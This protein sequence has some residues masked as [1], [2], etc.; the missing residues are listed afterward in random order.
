MRPPISRFSIPLKLF[1]LLLPMVSLPIAI[2]GY[3]AHQTS[4]SS[5]T[6]LSRE[7]QLSQASEAAQQIDAIFQG[8][9]S[10]LALLAQVVDDY[11]HPPAT[12][13]DRLA[14]G[15]HLVKIG[16]LMQH[17]LANTPNASQI[18]QVDASGKRLVGATKEGL[19]ADVAIQQVPNLPWIHSSLPTRLDISPVNERQGHPRYY[20]H[21]SRPVFDEWGVFE[22]ALV[23]ELDFTT[24]IDLVREIEIGANGYGFLVDRAGRTIAHPRFNPYQYDLTRYNDPRLREFIVHMLSGETGW[25][26]FNEEGEKAAAFAPVATTGWSLAVSIPI[27]EFTSMAEVHK[28]NV[29]QVVVVMIL[30]SALVAV[31]VSFRV[32]RPMRNLVLATEQVAAGDLSKEITVHSRDELGLLSE[33][34][35]TMIRS[36]RDIQRELVASEKLI[37]LGRFSAG[38]A[39]EIRNPLNAM[40]GAIAYLQRRRADDP[41][42]AEYTA[43]IAEEVDRLNQFAGDFLLYARQ[44]APRKTPTDINELLRSVLTLL[45]SQ[46]QEKTIS[47]DFRPNDDLPLVH[48]DPQ[49]LQQ[50]FLNVLINALDAMSNN[51]VLS[52]TTALKEKEGSARL[53]I[54]IADNGEGIGEEALSVIFDPF[55]S[56]KDTGTGLGLPISR[57]IIENHAGHL[58]IDSTPGLGTVVTIDMP[59]T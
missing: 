20:L 16:I 50:V 7:H 38:V 53:V 44:S 4:V 14:P 30:L 43:I 24:I 31:I 18:L 28:R 9:I 3:W 47:V 29:I 2:V 55:Y 21:L 34:F 15:E 6:K 1:V 23:L 51:G 58:G 10:T 46:L 45:A 42:V 36:L 52:I 56:T 54:T 59:L 27:E 22:G 37:S 26:T 49:Q 40:K 12:A 13:A 11:H 57:S 5:V 19:S 32:V 48:A 8:G 39:H 35:N 33:S 25:M 41:L 17:I